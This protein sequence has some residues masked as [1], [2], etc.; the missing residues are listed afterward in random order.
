[1]RGIPANLKIPDTV[2]C[3]I[4]MQA[5]AEKTHSNP[6]QNLVISTK[7]SHWHADFFFQ[8]CRG[9]KCILYLHEVVTG[10]GWAFLSRSEHPPIQ[11]LVW[12]LV[13]H[14]R[15]RFQISFGAL[16]TDSGGELYGSLALRQA[17]AQIG[18]K[19]E[20]TGGNNA[21]ANGPA[22]SGG[23]GVKRIMRCLLL[24]GGA[25]ATDWCFGAT[26]GNTLANI[27]PHRHLNYQSS[28]M[29]LHGRQPETSHLRI[30]FAMVFVLIS[31]ASRRRQDQISQAAPGIFL[32]YQG[33]GRVLVYKDNASRV[34][35]DHHAVVNELRIAMDPGQRNL[36]AR[37]LQGLPIDLPQRDF[38]S[39]AIDELEIT[40]SCW[41]TG[42]LSSVFI[43]CL[44]N[45]GVL[46]LFY[47][48]SPLCR[49]QITG[50]VPA[51][52][53]GTHFEPPRW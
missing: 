36:A 31:Q 17:L 28:H 6:A 27:R 8:L 42:S 50:I 39:A 40:P 29:E 49:C 26:N 3:P 1:V 15:H 5:S 14:T 13:T 43:L 4:C 51:S 34:R 21:A 18:C 25:V 46:G 24:G 52:P 20:T 48:Y 7:G 23:G 38:L 30:L 53:A 10:H 47:I 32:G 35:Y 9:Y 22:E 11:L 44:D 37:V 12:F 16:R 19:M 45:V 41:T 2:N 33:T